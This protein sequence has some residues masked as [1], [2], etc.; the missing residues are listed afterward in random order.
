M[1]RGGILFALILALFACHDDDKTVAPTG[2]G[3]LDVILTSPNNDDGAVLLTIDGAVDSVQGDPYVI[4][5]TA[6]GTGARLVVTGDVVGGV[7]ARLYVPDVGTAD[8]YLANLDEVAQ[9]GTFV[10]RP[11]TSYQLELRIER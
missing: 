6:S 4:F 10:L 5:S 9:R 3:V 8:Q 1:R 2:P 11:G 7:I